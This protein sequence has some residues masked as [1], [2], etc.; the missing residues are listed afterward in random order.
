M[1][2]C[3]QEQVWRF[4][5]QRQ[6]ALSM[7]VWSE[8]WWMVGSVEERTLGCF[9][10]FRTSQCLWTP[11][12]D[13]PAPSSP[14]SSSANV[15]HTSSLSSQRHGAPCILCSSFNTLCFW[16]VFSVCSTR[17]FPKLS[18]ALK[19][20]CHVMIGVW[21]PCFWSGNLGDFKNMLI[22]FLGYTFTERKLLSSDCTVAAT[23]TNLLGHVC[24]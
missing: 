22:L 11:A 6:I 14:F 21:D 13:A 8:E 1:D 19:L 23:N 5:L 24:L 16:C 17:T 12:H 9:C 20:P 4:L 3:R 2:H 18:K 7:F 15:V 10:S